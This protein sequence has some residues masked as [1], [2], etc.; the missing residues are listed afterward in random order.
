MHDLHNHEHE[1]HVHSHEHEHHAHSHEH[2]HH[3]HSHEHEHHAHSH[4]DIT[5]FDSREQAVS[6]LT[7]LLEHNISHAEEL[8]EICHKLEA[9]GEVEAAK[10]LDEAVDAFR[11]G[12]AAMEKALDILKE[13][14][15]IG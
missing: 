2:E 9:G 13:Q 6:I 8:H 1:H 7:Y 15:G 3:A 5:A 11:S 10:L 14:E 12:N 4:E